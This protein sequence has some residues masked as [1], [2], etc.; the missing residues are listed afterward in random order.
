MN[1]HA[2]SGATSPH[3]DIFKH[4]KVSAASPDDDPQFEEIVHAAD[5]VASYSRS[6]AES[7]F[8]RDVIQLRIDRAQFRQHAVDLMALIRDVAPIEGGCA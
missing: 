1:Y 8:R 4:Q 3:A 2:A 7:A 6:L 5:L